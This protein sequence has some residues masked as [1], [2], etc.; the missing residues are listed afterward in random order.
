MDHS[1]LPRMS[2]TPSRPAE[3]D[4]PPVARPVVSVEAASTGS[5]APQIFLSA[6]LG[7]VYTY[8]GR[9]FGGWLLATVTGRTF[10]TG[11]A[12][13][14]PV[15]PGD[16]A[17][18]TPVGYFEL[19]GGTAWSDMAVFVFGVALLVE[20][21]ALLASTRGGGVRTAMLGLA[22]AVTAIAVLVN[23]GVAGY[24]M[25]LGVGLPLFSILAVAFGGWMLFSLWDEFRRS[26]PMAA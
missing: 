25:S 26:R 8:L 5:V 24:L 18:G 11:V 15:N 19:A 9:N 3:H 17:Q 16:P 7:L 12:W 6:V 1:K 2:Q 10:D 22:V 13:G 20:A 4:L 14:A 23:L 21:A